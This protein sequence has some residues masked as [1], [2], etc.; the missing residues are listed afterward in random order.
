VLLQFL[1]EAVVISLAGGGIG[2]AMGYG[3]STFLRVY[4]DMTTLVPTNAPFIAVAF[5][6]SV[7]IFFGFYPARTA[8]ALDPIEALRFE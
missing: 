4:Q 3:I 8:A 6:A 1:S 7:G 5:S 2:I